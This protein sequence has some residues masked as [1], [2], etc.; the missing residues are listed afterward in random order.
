MKLFLLFSTILSATW[1]LNTW[2]QT[3]TPIVGI[4]IQLG[5]IEVA[6][7]DFPTTMDWKTA[8][9]ACTKL[10]KGWRLPTSRELESMYENRIKIGG[11]SEQTYWSSNQ[12]S[13]SKT[14]HIIVTFDEGSKWWSE[15][16]NAWTVRAVRTL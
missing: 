3:Q 13:F 1:S 8:K 10:G 14:G 12:A 9:K 5:S 11:F 16:E 7:N 15:G 6:Q 4:P 2:A